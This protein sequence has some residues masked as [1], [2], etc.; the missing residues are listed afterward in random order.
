MDYLH[1]SFLYA[2]PLLD[3]GMHM[4]YLWK[5]MIRGLEMEKI[6]KTAS[7]RR[8]ADSVMRVRGTFM[9]LYVVFPNGKP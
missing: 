5:S 2:T 6:L 8:S 9:R 1:A 4:P 3:R 7:G